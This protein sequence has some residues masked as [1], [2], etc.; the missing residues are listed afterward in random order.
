MKFQQILTDLVSKAAGQSAAVEPS[1]HFGDYTSNIALQSQEKGNPR[2]VAQGIVDKLLALKPEFIKEIDIAGPGFINFWIKDEFLVQ[3]A[4]QVVANFHAQIPNLG[5][6]KKAVIEFSSPNIAKPFTVGHLRST[7]IGN[8][9]ANLMELAG[10]TV[11]RDNHL[12]DWGTQFGKLIVAIKRWGDENEI[13]ASERPV[14]NLVELYVKFHEEAEKDPTLEDEAREWFTKLEK[15]NQEARELWQ[16][17]VDWSW[18]EFDSIY[19]Q[20]GVKFSENN[21]RGY[22]ESY[23]EDKM[24]PVIE[25]LE[26]SGNLQVGKE[27]AKLFFFPDEEFTPL[28]ILKKDGSTLYATRDLATDKFR[29]SHY[30]KDVLILNEVGAEQ[31]LYFKQIFK[32]EELLGWFKP[33]QRVHV[34]HGFFRFASGKMSTRKGNVIWLEDVISE[35]KKRADN[36]TEVAIGA[37]KWNDLKRSSHLDVV[38]DWD[39]MLSMT[40]NS[41]P[42]MQ[43]TVVRARSVL[44]KASVLPPMADPPR[45][46]N[47][48][49]KEEREVL[50]QLLYY[51]EVIARATREYAPHVLCTYLFELAQTFNSFYNS[52]PIL[53]D[54][55]NSAK[56]I[57]LTHAVS[58]VLDQ[59]LTVLGIQIPETM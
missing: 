15:G 37:I 6:G 33:G 42:Y 7:I 17:C 35:A 26:N 16:K 2:L 30:G 23:F 21:G 36:Q 50:R 29:L 14:K 48:L 31:E 55:E 40:G 58:K 19:S 11:Y 8:A 54:E 52:C 18:I 20:L 49:V 5:K 41:G 9:V 47:S 34:K 39:E 12:G 28:M 44:A 1:G 32:I 24:G 27:G 51:P 59:G 43:Y 57:M 3:N 25:E 56:R 10:F 45:A 4:K 13:S 53:G 22:G 46:D 38:F